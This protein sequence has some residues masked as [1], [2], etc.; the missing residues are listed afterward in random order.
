MK[1]Y[2]GKYKVVNKDWHQSLPDVF[3]TFDE[4]YEALNKWDKG[5][6]IEQIC[7]DSVDVVWKPEFA[8][9]VSNINF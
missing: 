6:S 4:A 5:A 3:D 9:F 1:Y 7:G 2:E 8:A